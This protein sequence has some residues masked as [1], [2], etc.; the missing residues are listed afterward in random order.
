MIQEVDDLSALS[1]PVS[2]ITIS[3]RLTDI[4]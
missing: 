4:L 1:P 3:F 2:R